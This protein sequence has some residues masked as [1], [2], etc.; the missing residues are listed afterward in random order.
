MSLSTMGITQQFCFSLV[1][2]FI[3]KA[4]VIVLGVRSWSRTLAFSVQEPNI[5]TSRSNLLK[6]HFS[7]CGANWLYLEQ[8]SQFFCW[9]SS[10][11]RQGLYLWWQRLQTRYFLQQQAVHHSSVLPN[12]AHKLLTH[13][14]KWNAFLMEQVFPDQTGLSRLM[15]S[16]CT[17]SSVF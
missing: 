13:S 14:V 8:R 2:A 17:F 16:H 3:T 9:I 5:K 10:A 11:D 1:R 12:P 7:E 6:Q 4:K 15:Q